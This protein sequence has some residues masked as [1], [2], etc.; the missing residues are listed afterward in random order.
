[1]KRVEAH[2][3]CSEGCFDSLGTFMKRDK[4]AAKRGKL[5]IIIFI[6]GEERGRQS[7]HGDRRWRSSAEKEERQ[8][9]PKNPHEPIVAQPRLRPVGILMFL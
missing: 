1:M 8:D 7:S 9:E 6:H 3:C 4:N 5:E 2:N